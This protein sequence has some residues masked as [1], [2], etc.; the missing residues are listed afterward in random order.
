[1]NQRLMAVFIGLLILGIG[2][3]ASAGSETFSWTATITIPAVL[4]VLPS[5][6]ELNLS[7][8]P[9]TTATT[10]V[11][12]SVGT[13]CW[14]LEL[15][16]G[17]LPPQETEPAFTFM[18]RFHVKAQAPPSLWVEIPAFTLSSPLNLPSPAWTEYTLSIRITVPGDAILGEYVRILR[19]SFRSTTTALVETRD[20]SIR[21]VVE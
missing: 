20:I 15:F 11:T 1:M 8:A 17:L 19:L 2:F 5:D 12:L 3:L 7:L 9:G 4:E 21:I 6:K 14:P 13:N 16:L 18:Y 10:S